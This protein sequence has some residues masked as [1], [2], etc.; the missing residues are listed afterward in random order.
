MKVVGQAM[1]LTGAAITGGLYYLL[2]IDQQS[3]MEISFQL[4]ELQ[5]GLGIPLWLLGLPAMGLGAFYT[6][7]YKSPQPPTVVATGNPEATPFVPPEEPV[8]EGGKLSVDSIDDE[9][10]MQ[11]WKV[12]VQS[13]MKS[14]LLPS[15]ATLVE[16]PTEGVQIGLILTRT[17]P[18]ATKQ[19]CHALAEMLSKIPTPPRVR[20]ELIDVMATGIPIKNVTMGGFT[21]FFAKKDFII[22]EQIDG[23]DIRFNR[24][25]DCWND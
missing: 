22:T 16:N 23:L 19:A 7:Q 17:T 13:E 15:G 20:I 12:H 25:D 5:T 18:Q 1:M 11:D 24:P 2:N 4:I 8:Q 9:A 6:F 3:N 14:I 10:F 21:K